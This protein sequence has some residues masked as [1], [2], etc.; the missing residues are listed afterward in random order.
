MVQGS[1]WHRIDEGRVQ[2]DLCPRL[3]KLHEG[4]RGFCW[5]RMAGPEGMEL[6]TYGRASGFCIDP[7]EK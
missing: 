2:C 3:C 6:A 1:W 5:V 7:I 4:Q